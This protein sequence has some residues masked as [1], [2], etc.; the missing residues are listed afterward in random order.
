MKMEGTVKLCLKYLVISCICIRTGV[1]MMKN[2]EKKS[3]LTREHK[4]IENRMGK[5]PKRRKPHYIARFSLYHNC[6]CEMCCPNT[7]DTIA[8]PSLRKSISKKSRPY[9]FIVFQGGANILESLCR[10][11]GGA[12]VPDG[13]NR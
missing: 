8:P 12:K 3:L 9:N 1:Y 4:W 7:I 6:R 5:R 13:T 11:Q 10:F 2:V